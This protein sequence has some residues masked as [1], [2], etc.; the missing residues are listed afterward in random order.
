LIFVT[1]GQGTVSCG[2]PFFHS[3]QVTTLNASGF[4]STSDK[5]VTLDIDKSAVGKKLFLLFQVCYSGTTPFTDFF[6]HKNV[7]TGVLPYCVL[8]R[9][10]APCTL[11][12]TETRAGDVVER[13]EVPPGDPRFH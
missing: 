13:F 7:T 3:P 1:I 5:I 6:G 10:R 9:N 8:V 4:T 12:T 11:S 2:D